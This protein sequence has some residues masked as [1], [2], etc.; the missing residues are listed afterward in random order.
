MTLFTNGCGVS[1]PH[2]QPTDLGGPLAA[3][4]PDES[5]QF[6]GRGDCA[7]NLLATMFAV[8]KSTSNHQ[9]PEPN[10]SRFRKS[11]MSE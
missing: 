4:R 9:K 3:D 1:R 2:G 5:E 11:W 10:P 7:S 8:A 6:S